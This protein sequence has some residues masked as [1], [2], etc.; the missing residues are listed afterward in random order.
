MT[1]VTNK[2]EWLATQTDDAGN[3]LAKSGANVRGRF[4]KAAN[5]RWDE[6]LASGEITYEPP[7]EEKPAKAAKTVE[8]GAAAP[9]APAA[10]PAVVLAPTPAGDDAP[11]AAAGEVDA[12][13]VRS[14]A[15]Q[16]GMKV[17]ERGR[18]HSDIISAY[19]ADN[20]AAPR[21][22]TP[23]DVMPA[24]K[25]RDEAVAWGIA[26]R[27]P[28]Q[29]AYISEPVVALSNC[30]KCSKG[31]MFCPGHGEHG[32]PVQPTYMTAGVEDVAVL[33]TKPLV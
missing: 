7:V 33:L 5:A 13:L 25:Y 4:S 9:V 31:I 10:G 32:L 23:K 30:G 3:A 16:R 1:T 29:G 12:K 11:V 6:A 2:R 18:I 17:G 20:G 22:A 8:T 21:R 27:K 19:L 26:R 28:D 15:A 24:K 14:W